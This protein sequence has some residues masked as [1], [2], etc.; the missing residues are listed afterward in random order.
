MKNRKIS[1]QEIF[2][3][4]FFGLLLFAKGIGLYDGQSSFKIFL[5]MALLCWMIKMC[6]VRLTIKEAFVTTLLIIVGLLVYHFSG[7]KAALVSVLVVAGIKDVSVKRVFQIGL[8]IWTVCFIGMVTLSLTEMVEPLMLVHNKA[9]LG[10]VIRNALGYTH[11]NVLHISYVILIAFW[12]YVLP[13]KG[14]K[15]WYGALFAFLGNL[16]IFLYSLSYTGFIATTAYLIL[17]VYFNLRTKRTATENIVIQCLMPFCVLT[18]FMAPLLLTGRAFEIAD[19]LVNTRFK[20]SKYYLVWE[21]ITLFGSQAQSEGWSIDCSY[22]YCLINY[23]VIL[24]SLIMLGYFFLIRDL[25][26][27]NRGKRLAL[28]LGLVAAGFTEP[29]MFNFSFKNLILPFLGEYLYEILCVGNVKENFFTKEFQILPFDRQMEIPFFNLDKLRGGNFG[30]RNKGRVFLFSACLLGMAAGAS[31]GAHINVEPYVVVNKG[32]SDRVGGKEDYEI[33]GE[34]PEEI[35]EHSLKIK[36]TEPDT[37]V[38]VLE[39]SIVRME[40]VRNIVS[41]ALVG[42]AAGGAASWLILKYRQDK[43]EKGKKR[44]AK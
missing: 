16:Y 31:L 34:L 35:L 14:K 38:Y 10:F 17:T 2:Y 40:K 26:K 15:I 33:F 41:T 36:C 32:Y 21:N 37:K 43:P 27:K 42:M 12:F 3:L 23:G 25:L 39:G 7:D 19:K 4:L 24:F 29:F 11:P 1:L 8:A 18:S 22:V 44:P 5:I 6:L 13:C 9:G 30:V 28:V 20:W